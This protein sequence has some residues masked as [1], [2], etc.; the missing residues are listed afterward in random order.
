MADTAA[1]AVIASRSCFASVPRQ[2]PTFAACI[3]L[4]AL[5]SVPAVTIGCG[6]DDDEAL[7]VNSCVVAGASY[8]FETAER[9]PS[10]PNACGAIA[11]QVLIVPSS[12]H[13]NSDIDGAGDPAWRTWA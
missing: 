9:D 12:G 5:L 10:R 4:A 2:D 8:L 7:E 11:D 3:T 6:S 13:R 1:R